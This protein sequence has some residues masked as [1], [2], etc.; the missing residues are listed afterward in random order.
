MTRRSG[1]GMVAETTKGLAEELSIWGPLALL[2]ASREHPV[3]QR[4][5]RTR[6]LAKHWQFCRLIEAGG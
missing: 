5:S 2:E 4:T 6:V 3:G 1:C